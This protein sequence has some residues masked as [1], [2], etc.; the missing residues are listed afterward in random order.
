MEWNLLPTPTR[1]K[2]LKER[3]RDILIDPVAEARLLAAAPQ[4]LRDVILLMQDT[5][6]RPQDVFRM[7]WEHVNWF[8][9]VLFIPYGKTKNSRRWVPLS[10]RAMKALKQRGVHPSGWVFP[11]KYSQ[12]GHITNVAKQWIATRKAVG[13]DVAVK[14]YC[15]RHTFATDAL[16]RTGTLQP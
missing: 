16:E 15:C 5:G 4:P 11:S 2:P 7:R 1:I 12:S 6:M 9:R 13:L 10:E 8:K 14:L 3:G